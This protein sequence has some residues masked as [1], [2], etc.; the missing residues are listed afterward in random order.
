M[1]SQAAVAQAPVVTETRKGD[2]GDRITRT[3]EDRVLQDQRALVER[4]QSRS[5]TAVNDSGFF[6]RGQP[7]VAG[8][9]REPAGD[10]QFFHHRPLDLSRAESLH[11][12]M[13]PKEVG[14]R[15]GNRMRCRAAITG[16]GGSD[17]AADGTNCVCCCTLYGRRSFGRGDLRGG[18][19]AEF[20]GG[21]AIERDLNGR[22][23][24]T[25]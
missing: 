13:R 21:L 25:T 2:I 23:A 9:G 5:N 1:V 15:W 6:E 4:R 17:Y 12:F 22:D 14:R 8:S 18:R 3:E 20:A 19:K 7:A 11:L 16:D 10:V 24:L